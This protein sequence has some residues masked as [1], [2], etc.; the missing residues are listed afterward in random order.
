MDSEV[1]NDNVVRIYDD[2]LEERHPGYQRAMIM[3]YCEQGS[4][5][6]DLKGRRNLERPRHYRNEEMVT[7]LRQSVELFAKA[8]EMGI[9]HCDIKPDN[10]FL[11]AL[12]E[13]DKTDNGGYFKIGDFGCAKVKQ[14]DDDSASGDVV[15]TVGYLSPIKYMNFKQMEGVPSVD[16]EDVARGDVYSLGITL[17]EL[18]TLKPSKEF[19]EAL[20]DP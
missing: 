19:V 9:Y 8:E 20:Y 13:K 15:G 3:E 14:D 7:I 18:M 5:D 10:F 12:N 4:M 16:S 2:F 11:K 17:L 6:S 1:E